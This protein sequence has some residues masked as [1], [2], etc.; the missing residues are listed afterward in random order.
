MRRRW[1]RGRAGDDRGA[2][3]V[4]LAIVLPILLLV[5]AAILD[6]GFLFQRYEVLTNAAR[7]G[8]RLAA[9]PGYTEDQV[10]ARVQSYL[11]ASGLDE[12]PQI[13]VTPGTETIG[14]PVTG[15]VTISLMTV[16]VLYDS[17][18]AFIGPFAG[19]FGGSTWTTA[20]LKASSTMRVEGAASGS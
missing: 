9:L 14:E 12:T 17:P 13:S 18:Y 6:F 5:F 2:E 3:L 7:E 16:E 15:T 8:A 4:E 1:L 20:T 11:T 19:M 10:R